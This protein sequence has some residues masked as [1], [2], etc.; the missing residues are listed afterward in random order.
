MCIDL[1]F[2]HAQN[3]GSDRLSSDDSA[4]NL[5]GWQIRNSKYYKQ[6]ESCVHG[7]KNLLRSMFVLG[8]HEDEKEA[9][10]LQE[11]KWRIYTPDIFC[12]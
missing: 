9:I 7:M 2:F 6:R 10:Y 4:Q 8:T 3:I 1:L 5:D 12:V 11:N